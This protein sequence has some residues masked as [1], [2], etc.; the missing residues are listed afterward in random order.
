[1]AP[2]YYYYYY[3]VG[4]DV[5]ALAQQRSQGPRR[6][7]R[8][9]RGEVELEKQR[10]G[11]AEEPE[12][13]EKSLEEECVEAVPGVAAAAATVQE[14]EDQSGGEEQSV[15]CD[16]S[17]DPNEDRKHGALVAK[18]D[19]PLVA[20]PYTENVAPERHASSGA[21]N[22]HFTEVKFRKL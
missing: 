14:D 10:G 13:A 11:D 19:V 8:P 21:G 20:E 12:R 22:V 17:G 4:E 3:Y 15:D 1:M 18:H 16:C 2:Y 5:G 9:H 7:P 6:N